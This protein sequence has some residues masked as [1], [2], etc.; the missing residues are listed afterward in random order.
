MSPYGPEHQYLLRTVASRGVV[1]VE[2]ANQILA[3]FGVNDFVIQNLVTEINTNIRPLQ[4]SIKITNDEFTSEEVLVFLSHGYDDATKSQ[5]IFS[6]TELEYFRVLIE[7]IMSTEGRQLTSI[8]AL[9]LV[10]SMKSS[11]TKLNAQKLL[12]TWCR[13]KYLDKEENNYALGVR[14]IQEFEGYLRENMPD[15]IEECFLCKQIV[16]RGY[17]CIA[18]AKAVHTRCLYKYLEK[19]HKWPCCKTDFNEEQL[20]NINNQENSRLF[21]SQPQN[22]NEVENVE[23]DASLERSDELTQEVSTQD[24]IPEVSQRVSKKRKR[25]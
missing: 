4:Q 8:H 21:Q 14:T 7:Q 19:V 12:D 9:N 6:A 5:N 15:T 13:M 3:S 11:F 2:N 25:Q 1:T 18:C 20:Q 17:N 10:G 22:L 24:I 16:F 23:E